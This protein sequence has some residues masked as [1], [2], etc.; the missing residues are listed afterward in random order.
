MPVVQVS[1]WAGMTQKNKKK[2]AEGITKVFEELGIP[3]K[4]ITIIINEVP[5]TNWVMGGILASEIT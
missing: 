2:V 4:G 5:K 1:T 3:K